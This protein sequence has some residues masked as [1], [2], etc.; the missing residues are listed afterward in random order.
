M[1]VIHAPLVVNILT[2]KF[3]L[4]DQKSIRRR[5]GYL[6]NHMCIALHYSNSRHM[7]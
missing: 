6:A 1:T 3:L 4:P 7:Q 2:I 5:G